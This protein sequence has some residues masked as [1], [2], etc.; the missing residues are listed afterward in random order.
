MNIERQALIDELHTIEKDQHVKILYACESGSRAWGFDSP[1]SDYDVRFIYVRSLKDYLRLEPLD[2]VINWKLDD[3]LDING[4]DLK[5]ALVLLSKS[6]PSI[7]EWFYS[8]IQYIKTDDYDEFMKLLKSRFQ[9]KKLLYHY[10]SMAKKTYQTHI[11]GKDQVV[12]KKYF[13]V[14]RPLLAAR[15][16][17]RYQTMPPI[18][19]DDLCKVLDEDSVKDILQGLLSL[20]R[21]SDEMYLIEPIQILNDFSE[22]ELT[23]I[24]KVI[25]NFDAIK[26]DINSSINEFFIKAV[27][28][29][30]DVID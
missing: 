18:M 3:V 21:D 8:P 11:E 24:S 27:Q 15:W 26:Y 17:I 6:N 5:K 9:P 19:F 12:L 14:L 28:K 30:N 4:W 13:Y 10:M 20:K 7:Y 25:D 16:L 2:D 29:Y 1:D 23:V 22:N